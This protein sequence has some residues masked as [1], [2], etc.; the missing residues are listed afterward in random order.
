MKV[1]QSLTLSSDLSIANNQG[2]I[3]ISGHSTED[4]LLIQADSPAV[5]KAALQTMKTNG[6]KPL[7]L[8][9]MLQELRDSPQILELRVEN[10]TLLAIEADRVRIHYLRLFPY[11]PSLL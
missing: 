5:L 6:L 9:S 2:N 10:R 1:L 8:R 7:R 4:G 11:L 3:R